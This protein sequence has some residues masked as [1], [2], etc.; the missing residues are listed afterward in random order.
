MCEKTVSYLTQ[1]QLHQT[2]RQ[3]AIAR[4]ADY[5]ADTILK[6]LMEDIGL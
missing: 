5:D 1:P 2:F 6:R 4:A 3:A